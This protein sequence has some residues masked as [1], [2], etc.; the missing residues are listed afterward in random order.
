[1]AEDWDVPLP[2]EGLAPPKQKAKRAESPKS[3]QEAQAT[4]VSYHRLK[5]SD[6]PIC[7]DCIAEVERVGNAP[8]KALGRAAYTRTVG[9]TSQV[10][11][12]QHTQ[13]WRDSDG[14]EQ[15][16]PGT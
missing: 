9:S 15:V 16:R 4:K 10:L 7:S 8:K 5:V 1:M 14:L 2:I 11:C 13:A 3:Q 6:P 12:F